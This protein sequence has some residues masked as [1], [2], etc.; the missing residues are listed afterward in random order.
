MHQLLDDLSSFGLVRRRASI[1]YDLQTFPNSEH[2]IA[3]RLYIAICAFRSCLS[4]HIRPRFVNLALISDRRT[5]GFRLEVK[6][7]RQHRPICEET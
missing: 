2:S 7:S 1:L 5:G 4:I 6:N 3:Y